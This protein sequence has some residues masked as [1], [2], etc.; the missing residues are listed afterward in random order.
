MCGIVGLIDYNKMSNKQILKKMN[1]AI[2]HRGP[3]DEGYSFYEN[4][5]FQVG[6][7]HRRLAILD[8]SDAAHQ[9]MQ[10]ENIEIIYN[11]EIYNFK[12]IKKELE[13]Y[14]Y[15]FKSNSDTEVILKAYH[16]W[17]MEFVN[18]LIGMFAI[19]IFDKD[20]NKIFLIRDRAGVKPLYYYEK[21][22][23]FL[24][25]SELKAFHHHPQ[26]KKELDY[27]GL[28]CFFRYGYV[29][30]P[31]TIFKYTHKLD[32]GYYIEYD[33]KLKEKK[34]IKYW[35]VYDYYNK[36][37]IE[38][39]EEEI[40]LN[41]ENLLQ[42][43]FNYR[44]IS[45]VPIGIFLSGG[46]DS[47]AVSALLQ[48]NSINKL[49]TFTI[50]FKEKNFDESI[51][52]K[53]IAKILG[54]EHYEYIVTEKDVLEIIP[55]LSY[56]YDEPFGDNSS[57]PTILVSK[58]AKTQVKVALSAD[59]SD[60][61]FGGYSKYYQV[62]KLYKNF[63]KIYF[64]KAIFNLI[65]P[66]VQNKFIDNLNLFPNYNNK[67]NKFYDMLNNNKLEYI[68]NRA[69][70]YLTD[71]EI[72]NLID[73]MFSIKNNFNTMSDLIFNNDVISKIMAVD[74]KTYLVD[75]ILTKV[76]RATMSVSLEGREPFLDQRIIEFVAQIPIEIKLKNNIPKYL[77]K[78]IVHK[79][80]PKELMERPKQG[81]SIPLKE[82]YDKGL[83]DY[84]FEFLNEKSINEVGVLNYNV[85]KEILNRYERG[86]SFL[87]KNI[88]Y[89]F[90]F[91]Q[92]G[93]KWLI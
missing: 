60:E 89:I 61:I 63:N 51:F 79:Y 91:Q 43:S 39:N 83:K 56:I 10:F 52:A 80:I 33:L 37:K 38:M 93:K 34:L 88:W 15:I 69:N 45:D 22:G 66:L 30:S 4:N 9:P 76:D 25:G 36:P 77:L 71:Y 17:G 5:S 72:K 86:E 16:K 23:L 87:I 58:L 2:I 41:L 78:Q 21:N 13:K 47:T 12:E 49:K 14:R 40:I 62:P 1:D 35:D 42:S 50:G 44:M 20:K 70:Y 7:A 28:S 8:L 31:Y 81:F 73:Q 6:L 74:Y 54:T 26:F 84:F 85:V 29:T 46:Y 90:I 64:L 68:F 53:K 67:M 75:N 19:V 82:W 92:W 11:G 57:I 55:E 3:D 59:G 48:K 65:R 24:F 27:N 18:K 32:P